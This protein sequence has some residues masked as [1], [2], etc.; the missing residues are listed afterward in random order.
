MAVTLAV[1][2]S[3]GG[4]SAERLTAKQI[5]EKAAAHYD[6]VKDYTTD[7]KLTVN[8][9]SM[10]VPNMLVKVYFKKPDKLHL[11]SKDG[12]AMLPRNGLVVGNPIR[13]FAGSSDLSVAGTEKVL[14]KDCYVI[15]AT[16]QHEDRDMQSTIWVEKNTW[17]VRQI[18]ANP[19]WGPSIKVKLWYSRVAGKYWLPS[20]TAAQVSIPP[21]PGV[22]PKDKA[23]QGQPTIVTIKFSNYRVNTGLDDKIFQEKDGSK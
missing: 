15:K 2:L 4:A 8:S 7:A 21:I 1:L 5:V 20:Q 23:K 18:H 11:E 6:A 19:E 12:F 3:V 14:G 10:H 16:Y 17:L 13:D 9:P 22:E